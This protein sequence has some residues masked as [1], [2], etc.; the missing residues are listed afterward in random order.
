MDNDNWRQNIEILINKMEQ[1][2]IGQ[3]EVD[4]MYNQFCR[5]V[6][7]EM[8]KYLNYKQHNNKT[9]KRFKSHKPF[10]NNELTQLWKMMCQKERQFRSFVGARQVKTLKRNEFL[11]ARKVFDKKLHF[12]ERQYN[13]KFIE[14]LENNNYK[15]KGL[16]EEN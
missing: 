13:N 6:F 2:Q 9:R 16:L 10:L 8:D 7:A 1:T 15:P 11:S 14:N 12:H 3:K 4:N 5:C